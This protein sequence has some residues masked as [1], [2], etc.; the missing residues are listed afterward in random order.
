MFDIERLNIPIF[1]DKVVRI[2]KLENCFL[3]TAESGREIRSLA[4]ILATGFRAVRNE[5]RYYLKGVRIT[6]KGYEHFP[7]IIQSCAKDAN[8]QGMVV[9]GNQKS[10]HLSTLLDA[11]SGGAGEVTLL[12]ES[13]LL[14]VLGD[15]HVTGVRV[16]DKDGTER[17]IACAS[18]LM[19]YNA[20]ELNPNFDISGLNLARDERGFIR[21]DAHLRS[22]V[23]GLF[24]AGDITGRYAATLMALGDGVCAG[25]GAYSYA[26]ETKFGQ[27]PVLFAYAASDRHLP[28]QPRDLP[29]IPVDA[30]PVALA[31]APDWVDGR[32]DLKTLAQTRGC[33]SADLLAELK[34]AVLEKHI[35]FHRIHGES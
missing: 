1:R 26:F 20:M 21:V 16:R 30:I 3:C 5:S 22:S 12:T 24:A 18:V 32:T 19:D 23:D 27:P 17:H 13:E 4:V 28:E 34:N 2:E 6:F 35:T 33:S 15:T 9:V 7:R 14:E 31:D 10:H 29:E 25:L 11:W 8:G